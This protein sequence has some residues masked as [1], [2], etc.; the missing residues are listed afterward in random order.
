M[1]GV[2]KCSAEHLFLVRASLLHNPCT[3]SAPG[4]QEGALQL[5]CLFRPS[6]PLFALDAWVAR[7]LVTA[8][9]DR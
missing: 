5:A 6:H 9:G 8:T 7:E 3:V 1:A 2:Q 4:A